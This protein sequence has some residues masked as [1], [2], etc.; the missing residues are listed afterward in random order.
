MFCFVQSKEKEKL[1]R[2]TRSGGC[3]WCPAWVTCYGGPGVWKLGQGVIVGRG[4]DG[5]NKTDHSVMLSI[6]DWVENGNPPSVI[7]D[8][9]EQ[10][11]ERKHCMW[12]SSKA[13]WAGKGRSIH[14]GDRCD[15]KSRKPHNGSDSAGDL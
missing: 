9:D 10:S 11:V 4:T 6:V 14:I 5:I 12:S 8:T 3:S 2:W 1:A 13:V 7:I 15:D